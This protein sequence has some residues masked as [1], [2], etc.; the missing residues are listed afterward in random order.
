M[1]IEQRHALGLLPGSTACAA[2]L[3][4]DRGGAVAMGIACAWALFNLLT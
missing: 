1:P 2:W 3:L 4:R